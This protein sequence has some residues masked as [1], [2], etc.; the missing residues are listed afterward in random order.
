MVTN[1]YELFKN[2]VGMLY[3]YENRKLDRIECEDNGGIGVSTAWTPDEG[4]ETALLTDT[5]IPVERYQTMEEAKLGHKKWV[6]YAKTTDDTSIIRLGLE[7]LGIKDK[8][9]ALIRIKEGN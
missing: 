4:Y 5:V 1:G 8:I 7:R 6:E 2:I 9:V 3:D